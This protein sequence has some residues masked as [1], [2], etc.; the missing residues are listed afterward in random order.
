M[1]TAGVWTTILS[2]KR[3]IVSFWWWSAMILSRAA[4]ICTTRRHAIAGTWITSAPLSLGKWILYTDGPVAGGW[5]GRR[6]HPVAHHRSAVWSHAATVRRLEHHWVPR[7]TR[8]TAVLKA[9]RIRELTVVPFMCTC[10]C[11][12]HNKTKPSTWS[13]SYDKQHMLFQQR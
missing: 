12:N 4:V 11:T 5:L 3:T 10:G 7:R 13:T 2:T 9:S 1:W 6:R 8:T